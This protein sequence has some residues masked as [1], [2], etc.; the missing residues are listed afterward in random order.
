[1]DWRFEVV[2][3]GVSSKLAPEHAICALARRGQDFTYGEVRL[4][5]PE[6]ARGHIWR[7][8][9]R[10]SSAQ[11]CNVR[12]YSNKCKSGSLVYALS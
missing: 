11:V 3:M 10:F 6:T 4:D 8:L 1:M 5:L 12:V 9:A 7:T 2:K